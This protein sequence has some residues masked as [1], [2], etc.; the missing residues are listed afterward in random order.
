MGGITHSLM[1][2]ALF[3]NRDDAL[4]KL[5][6]NMPLSFFENQDCI[7]VGI[8][9]NGILLANS[10]AQAIKAP[11]AFLFTSPI[12]APN[13]LECEIAMATETHD[14]VISDA[15]V[16]SF[17]ISL[18]YI[19]G[20]VKRQYEDKML[21][22]IYQYRKGNPL[23]SLK[24]KRVLLVDDGVDSGLTALSAI[25]S[26]TTLQAKTIYFATPVAPYEVTKVMEEVTDGLF[27][28]Y[29]TKTFVDIE[30][31]YKD[32]PPVESNVIEEI[33]SKIQS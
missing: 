30:Y 27:C 19:Y 7:V 13:N 9:F 23:I 15:L 25:K 5:L 22:L 32:Y 2:K 26:V 28:L 16:R 11:L 18:D 24:N 21:P 3:E 4:Q 14:V 6:N 33:F 31:Y 10:L 29:K 8:S 17:E 20:E 12:L 1:R